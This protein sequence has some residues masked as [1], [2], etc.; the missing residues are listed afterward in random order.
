[1][2]TSEDVYKIS[3]WVVGILIPFLVGGIA[4]AAKVESR[5]SSI[6]TMQN[7]MS[8]TFSEIKMDIREI[9]NFLIKK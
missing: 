8:K 4:W 2:K 7:E 6:E 5:V 9:K 3:K 1:M